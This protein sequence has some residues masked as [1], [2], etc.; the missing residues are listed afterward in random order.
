VLSLDASHGEGGGQILRAALSLAV[1][2]GRPVALTQI[3]ACRPKPGL[4]PQHL[5]VVRALTAISEAE[6][7]GDTLDST[8][9]RFSPRTVRGGSYRFDVGAVRGSAGSVSLLFQALLLPLAFAPVPSNLTLI[10]GTHVPWSP[11]VHYLSDVFLPTLRSIGIEA[12]ISLRRWG[13]YPK[14]G[15]EIG[16]RI[17]PTPGIGSLRWEQRA[18]PVSISGVSAVSRLPLSIAERQR[19]Q[20]LERLATRGLGA[21]IGLSADSGSLG[22]GTVLFLGATGPTS[23][24]GFAALGRR[25][26]PAEAVADEAVERLLAYL[27]TR[28]TVDDHLADQLVPILALGRGESVLTCPSLSSHLRTVAWVVQQ[29]L[30]A[31]IELEE[32]PPARVRIMPPAGHPLAPPAQRV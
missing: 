21:E 6:V 11:P 27:D 23:A 26:L 3:R 32:G 14:G 15:G 1:V 17:A 31:R 29:F 12:D 4:Q 28:A 19:R 9:L 24:G 25:G 10:G 20:A 13:W 2:L 22:P 18:T 5:A 7:S 30:A 8:E 16:A